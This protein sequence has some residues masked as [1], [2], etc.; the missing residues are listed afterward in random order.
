MLPIPVEGT[1]EHKKQL[2]SKFNVE[3][4]STLNWMRSAHLH[5]FFLH[6][7][8]LGLSVGLI[9]Q[10]AKEG[11][12]LG[13]QNFDVLHAHADDPGADVRLEGVDALVGERGGEEADAP[14][15]NGVISTLSGYTPN[16]SASRC[17]RSVTRTLKQGQFELTAQTVAKLRRRVL[18]IEVFFLGFY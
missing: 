8:F 6:T 2:C 18:Q 10:F 12:L 4:S 3:K 15:A 1:S 14:D 17:D 9:L 16:T 11:V 5:I 7:Y 13:Q